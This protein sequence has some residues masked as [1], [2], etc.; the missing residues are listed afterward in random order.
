MHLFYSRMKTSDSQFKQCLYFSS[1]ALARKVE[2]LATECWSRVGLTPSLAYLLITVLEHPGIQPGKISNEL[3]LTPSTISRLIEKLEDRKLLIRTTEGKITNVYPTP[4][5]KELLP[6]M[7]LCLESFY[8]KYTE[9]LGE[10][11]SQRFVQNLVRLADK[12]TT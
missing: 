3:Q 7:K 4:K 10:T 11:E 12:L 2:K 9:I 5:G 1:G 8:Q 6:E